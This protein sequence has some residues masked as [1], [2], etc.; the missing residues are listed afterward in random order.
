MDKRMRQFL[1][2]QDGIQ[3]LQDM[4]IGTSWEAFEPY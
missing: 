1:A 2:M 4:L 3:F